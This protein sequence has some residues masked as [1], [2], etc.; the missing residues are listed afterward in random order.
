MNRNEE[1][2]TR[3]KIIEMLGSTN[4]YVSG[5]EM[6][7]KL[8]LSRTAVWKHIKALKADGYVIDSVNNRGYKLESVPDVMDEKHIREHLHTKWLAE[9]IVYLP[10]TDSSNI[11]AKRLGENGGRNG[12][13]VVTDRQTAGRGRRGKSWIS[14]EGNCYFS[15]LLHPDVRVD[16]ASMITLIAAM[17]VA[18]AVHEVEGIE[19]MIKWPNDVVVNGKKICGILTESSTDLEYIEYVVVGIGINCNQKEFDEEIS[20]MASSIS[21]ET[22][23]DV[24]RAKLLA[25]FFECFEAY[26][27]TFM[28]T[29]DLSKL[30]DIYNEMLINRGRDVKIIDK[31]TERVL[32]AVGINDMGGLIVE[33]DK[34][35]QEVIISGEVSVRGLY[36]YAT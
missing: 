25:R 21:L 36:G 31:D 1:R 19:A 22:G 33:S 29:E 27:D 20:G 30:S 12:T 28:E 5:Q 18:K 3:E 8:K 34:G 2:G 24:E 10:E 16:R 9:E 23:H 11:Q 6:C 32:K 14:P 35:E 26:Y 13:V 15:M 4:E 7:E 17:A